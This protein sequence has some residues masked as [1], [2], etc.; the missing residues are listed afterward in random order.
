MNM[1]QIDKKSPQ[2]QF[3]NSNGGMAP[4]YLSLKEMA[5]IR[6]IRGIK[7]GKVTIKIKNYVLDDFDQNTNSRL[8]DDEGL[9]LLREEQNKYLYNKNPTGESNINNYN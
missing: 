1:P 8:R 2:A 6:R 3:A 9:E 5:L 7:Y 4:I